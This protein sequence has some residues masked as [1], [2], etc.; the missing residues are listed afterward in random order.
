MGMDCGA[1]GD[2]SARLRGQ[3]SEDN[4]LKFTMC[5]TDPLTKKTKV[6]KGRE[7]WVRGSFFTPFYSGLLRFGLRG[8]PVGLVQGMKVCRKGLR[9][10]FFWGLALAFEALPNLAKGGNSLADK[11]FQT[12]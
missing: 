8:H 2:G 11:T 5:G 9:T 7:C 6:R 4:K 10:N 12:S 1:C 3:S